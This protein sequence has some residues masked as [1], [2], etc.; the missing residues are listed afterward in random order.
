MKNKRNRLA[1]LL[2]ALTLFIGVG[3][4]VVTTTNLTIGGTATGATSQIDV[5]FTSAEIET[6]EG[7][8][9][10]ANIGT[11]D[12][13][14]SATFNVEGLKNTQE[15]VTATF[16]IKNDEN[17]LSAKVELDGAVV[18]SN[19]SFFTIVTSLD[20]VGSNVIIP[21]GETKTITVTVSLAKVPITEEE[22]EA[23]ITINL[24]ATPIQPSS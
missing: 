5:Y 6:V 9:T 20:T 1:W 12:N 19:S 10:S 17:D 23:Q 14:L 3:Y 4:A 11:G 21:A 8:T 22:N 7:L 13:P 18:N 16:T 24:K 15:E 2:V